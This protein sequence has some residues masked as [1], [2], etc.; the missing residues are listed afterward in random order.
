MPAPTSERRAIAAAAPTE[1]VDASPVVQA[2]PFAIVAALVAFMVVRDGGFAGTVWYPVAL[3]LLGVVVAVAL[4]AGRLLTTASRST[5]AAIGCLAAYTAWSY[6]SI[7]WAAVRGSA[8]DGSN[9]GL[10]Y[11]LVFALLA[12]WPA[13]GRALWPVLLAAGFAI[14]LEGAVTVEQAAS[15]A[16]PSQFLIGARLSEPLGYPNAT[17][18][19][20]M[21]MAWLMVGLASRPWLPAPARGLAFGLAGLNFTLN[22]LTESRGSVFTLPFAAVAYL[23]LVPGRLRSLA[24][25]ALV[26]LGFAPVLRPVLD[27]YTSDP[28]QL[29]EALRRAIDLG[30]VWAVLLALAGWLFAVADGRLRPPARVVRAAGLAVVAAAV[31]AA[32]GSLAVIRPWNDVGSAWHSF[33]NG[34]EPAGSSHFGGLGSNRYDFWRVGLIEFERHP[35]QGIGTDN[36]LVP[37]LQLRKSSEEPIYPHSLAIRLLSQTGIVGTALFIGFLALTFVVVLRIPAGRERDLA[38][39][40]VAGAVVWLLHGLVDWLWEM[41]ALGALAMALLGAACALAPRRPAR[42]GA[43][44]RASLVAIAAGGVVVVGALAATLTLPWLAERDV[45]RATTV[46]RG[47]PPAAFALLEQADSLNPISDEAD[48]VAGAIASR[49]HRYGV[50]RTRF[51]AAVDRSP[52]D[53]YSNLE[54]GIA[55]SLTGGR[56]VAAAAL[57]QALQLDPQEPIIQSVLHTFNSGRRIN[58]DAVDRAF[59]TAS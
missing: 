33:T 26:A 55:A 54:L 23:I 9:K 29:S 41:P 47:D 51:Q 24:T 15:A 20:F 42:L 10:F 50:M 44:R 2:A 53:W 16:N 36:F 17:A 4:S 11:L 40:L 30:L 22:L 7:G 52:D 25:L 27:V 48:L 3:I 43:R 59:A 58:S 45:Q 1:R 13:T 5:L 14:A 18:A 28:T 35:L 6:A 38:G 56:Q 21:M 32:A 46:W 19:L 12:S 31:L 37:Y 57:E 8:W 39:V 34:G 49:L